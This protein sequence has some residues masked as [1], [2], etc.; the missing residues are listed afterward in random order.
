MDH[1]LKDPTV[2]SNGTA[3]AVQAEPGARPGVGRTPADCLYARR[4]LVPLTNFGPQ[5]YFFSHTRKMRSFLLRA[6]AAPRR[7][8]PRLRRAVVARSMCTEADRS[9]WIPRSEEPAFV[10]DRRRYKLEVHVAYTRAAP[11]V[12]LSTAHAYTRPI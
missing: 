7:M 12:R 10:L 11:N 1:P 5:K 3:G 6:M 9:S 4:S 2:K 8:A